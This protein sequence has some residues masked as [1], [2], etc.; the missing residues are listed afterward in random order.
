MRVVPMW[1][2]ASWLIGQGS[3][4]AR[5]LSRRPNPGARQLQRQ[6][7]V[8]RDQRTPVELA[9]LVPHVRERQAEFVLLIRELHAILGLGLHL[10]EI[11]QP[12]GTHRGSRTSEEAIPS[13]AADARHVSRDIPRETHPSCGSAALVLQFRIVARLGVVA[14]GHEFLI[15]AAAQL[16]KHEAALLRQGHQRLHARAVGPGKQRFEAAIRVQQ[17]VAL[18]PGVVDAQPGVAGEAAPHAAE[19]VWQLRNGPLERDHAA[20]A[21][22]VVHQVPS[23]LIALVA[24]LRDE[25]QARVL[26]PARRQ[27]EGA[28]LE[29]ELVARAAAHAH[30]PDARTLGQDAHDARV[31]VQVDPF[32]LEDR[33]LLGAEVLWR[34]RGQEDLLREAVPARLELAARAQSAEALAPERRGAGKA[35]ALRRERVAAFELRA[36]DR[37]ARERHPR[38]RR[39][40]ERLERA[41][42]TGPAARRAAEHA[43]ARPALDAD[44]LALDAPQPV[45]EGRHAGTPALEHAHAQA[46]ARELR[47]DGHA[48]RA[49]A[50][51]AQVVAGQRG[52]PFLCEVVDHPCRRRPILALASPIR[53]RLGFVVDSVH[54]IPAP[55]G[56]PRGASL[57]EEIL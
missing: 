57:S 15:G 54:V 11:A 27:H 5:S 10:H 19:E 42:E 3:A 31:E 35:V 33:A 56:F 44:A 47:G 48:C 14:Q 13:V 53:A 6:T 28:R 34:R 37:P 8:Q 30:A 18:L 4:P 21:L 40:I 20:V 17:A 49:R 51:H 46:R 16:P 7:L 52:G 12:N 39:E 45:G 50:D 25:Q 43:F 36:R 55:R 32:A 41:R 29:F 38:A 1:C 23:D 9:R 24:E 26:D 22:G 2:E